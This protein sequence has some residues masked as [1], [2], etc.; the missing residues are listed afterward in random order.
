MELATAILVTFLLVAACLSYQEVR[1]EGRAARDDLAQ[2]IKHEVQRLERKVDAFTHASARA[3]LL[4]EHA[5]TTAARAT[6]PASR[7]GA[8]AGAP[9]DPT[10]KRS[11]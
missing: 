7:P 6:E 11:S 1:R 4:A 3:N 2:L 10:P 5:V 8:L 9:P